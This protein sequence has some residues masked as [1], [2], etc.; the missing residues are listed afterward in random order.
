MQGLLHS[1]LE[2][3]GLVHQVCDRL[4]RLRA[5]R[6]RRRVVHR[7]ESVLEA[8]HQQ[9]RLVRWH[10]GRQ[11]LGRLGLVLAAA[12]AA[13]TMPR[14]GVCYATPGLVFRF[15]LV[16][17]LGLVLNVLFGSSNMF[18]L[19]VDGF[20]VGLWYPFGIVFGIHLVHMAHTY[21][22]IP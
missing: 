12:A 8:I 22:D 13:A 1:G 10:P 19:N 11:R 20:D 4:P 18:G 6:R 16:F 9:R 3:L 5:R 21:I 2:R 17:C 14:A 7:A 15:S